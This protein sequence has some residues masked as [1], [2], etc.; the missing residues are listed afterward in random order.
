MCGIHGG[1][2]DHLCVLWRARAPVCAPLAT[3][4]GVKKPT[5]ATWRSA[6]LRSAGSAVSGRFVAPCCQHADVCV[7]V[8]LAPPCGSSSR[9]AAPRLS[10]VCG[11]DAASLCRPGERSRCWL[12]CSLGLLTERELQLLLTPGV[13]YFQGQIQRLS[14]CTRHARDIGNVFAAQHP[15]T[16]SGPTGDHLEARSQLPHSLLHTTPDH[17]GL[18]GVSTEE[19]KRRRKKDSEKGKMDCQGD[20][21]TRRNDAMKKKEGIPREKIGTSNDAW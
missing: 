18:V 3:S 6:F 20:R 15:G 12:R 13:P 5:K 21:E 4:R 7:R 2:L 16:F 8:F 17:T 1:S 14:N 10:L 19:K 11:W 9:C